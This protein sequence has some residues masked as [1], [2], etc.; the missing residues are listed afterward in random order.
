[1]LEEFKSKV[2]AAALESHQPLADSAEQPD[3]PVT[4]EQPA[5]EAR[6]RKRNSEVDDLLELRACLADSSAARPAPQLDGLAEPCSLKECSDWLKALPPQEIAER[7][8]LQRLQTATAVLQSRSS[9]PQRQE[10]QQLLDPWN[11]L[12]KSKGRKRKC[13]EVKERA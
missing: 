5:I 4:V 11:V 2:T 10:V 12:Q 6:R 8:P 1:M 3:T 9:R 7:K 13:D